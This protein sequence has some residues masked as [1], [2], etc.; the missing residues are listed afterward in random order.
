MAFLDLLS[1]QLIT[2]EKLPTACLTIKPAQ[3]ASHAVGY[4]ARVH[5]GTFGSAVTLQSAP[6]IAAFF[7]IGVLSHFGF[8]LNVDWILVIYSCQTAS[9]DLLDFPFRG[10][11]WKEAKL[12]CFILIEIPVYAL[13]SGVVLFSS[14][15]CALLG[16][17]PYGVFVGFRWG[18]SLKN[19]L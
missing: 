4:S 5:A 12:P 15:K 19:T 10:S 6:L 17:L 2:P 11:S 16:L 3:R 14:L 7:Y 8:G 18:N 13:F 9:E 1:R